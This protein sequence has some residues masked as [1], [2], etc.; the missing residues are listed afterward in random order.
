MTLRQSEF[1]QQLGVA[2][3]K[4]SLLEPRQRVVVGVS[5]GPDSMAL[6][7]ALRELSAEQRFGWVLHAAHLHHGLR[8]SEAD[9]DAAFVKDA[10]DR[11]GLGCTVE[12][13]EPGAVGAA[14]KG[15]LAEAARRLRYA[16][17]GRV[18]ERIGA[19][20]VA[21][22][23]HADDRAETILHHAIRGTGMRGLRGMQAKRALQSGGSIQLVRP[24]LGFRRANVMAYLEDR[25]IAYCLDRTNEQLDHTRNR[26]RHR[27]LPLLCEEVNPRTVEALLRLGD[28]ACLL[29]SF[30]NEQAERLLASLTVSHDDDLLEISLGEL[31]VQPRALQLEVVRQAVSGFGLG[32][33][34]LSFAHLSAVCDM[35]DGS[36]GAGGMDLPGRLHVRRQADRIV[37]SIPQAPAC[38]GT[39]A[40]KRS[41]GDTEVTCIQTQG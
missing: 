22:A 39:K 1:C 14:G 35:I 24:L 36:E 2:I 41:I 20:S 33:R 7:H 40:A 12:R 27:I 11:L 15:S 28:Q 17:L 19:G 10:M 4:G 18:C 5:G 31:A 21:V 9:A 3:E 23:H 8:G 34:D 26:I 37:F 16:F 29:E 25:K 32:E 6:L 13:L 38:D 30:V